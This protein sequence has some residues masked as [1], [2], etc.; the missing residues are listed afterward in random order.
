MRHIALF[1]ALFL[2]SSVAAD[3]WPL[4]QPTSVFSENGDYFV[5]VVPGS[6]KTA[7]RGEFYARQEDRSY[8]LTA[9]VALRYESAPVVFLVS[10]EGR[11][12]MFDNWHSTG[13]DTVVSIYD[14]SGGLVKWYTLEDMYDE[15]QIK[16]IPT[17]VSSRW[18]R[19]RPWGFSDPDKQTLVYVMEHFGGSFQFDLRTG[20]KKYAAGN[21]T[22][23]QR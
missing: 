8:A 13:Y 6:G 23:Q 22:C 10:N 4:P 18:W 3:S 7:A 9:D 20:A 1:V 15:A 16:A 5:R 17:S 19:C 21:A 11:A 2:A 12:I 14:R